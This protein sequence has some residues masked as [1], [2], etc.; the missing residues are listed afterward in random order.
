MMVWLNYSGNLATLI[1]NAEHEYMN[2]PPPKLSI[3]LHTGCI[4]ITKTKLTVGDSIC[5]VCERDTI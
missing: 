1:N 5:Q 2:M 3:L 4:N